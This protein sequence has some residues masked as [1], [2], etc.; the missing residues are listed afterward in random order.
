MH[1]EILLVIIQFG[2]PQALLSFN[3]ARD[4]PNPSACRH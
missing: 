1:E 3:S 2:G 4:I